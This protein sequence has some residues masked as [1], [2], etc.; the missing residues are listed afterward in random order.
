MKFGLSADK[1]PHI[2]KYSGPKGTFGPNLDVPKAV[3]L[4]LSSWVLAS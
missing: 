2:I 4:T 3:K 1:T